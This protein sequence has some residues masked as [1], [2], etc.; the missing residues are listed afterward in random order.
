MAV[1]NWWRCVCKDN[2]TC[3]LV[4]IRGAEQVFVVHLQE[5]CVNKNW[6]CI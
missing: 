4:K 1:Y 6:G 3:N 2:D 5:E